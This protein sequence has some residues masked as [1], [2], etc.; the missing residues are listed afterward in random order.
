MKFL[1]ID[2]YY[3][4]FLAEFRASHPELANEPFDR[5]RAAL[6]GTCFG[7]SDYYSANL[8]KLG[9]GAQ[10]LIINDEHLQRRWA[11]E[12]N[13]TVQRAGLW[14]KIQTLP[15]IHRAI[16]RPDWMQAITL[17]QIAEIRPDVV[18]VQDLSALNPE[19][20]RKI[21]EMT[22][23]LVGQIACPLPAAE[24]LR[25]FQLIL[26]SFPHYVDRFRQ[27]GIASEYLKIAF[28]PRVLDR[29]GKQERSYDVSFVGSFSPHHSE[30]TKLLERIA[31]KQPIHIWGQGSQFLSPTSPLRANYHGPAWGLDMYKILAQSKI[32]INRHISVAEDYA[33][34]MRLYET[35]GMGALLMTDAKKNLS[36]LFRVDQ[37][38]IAYESG[39]DLSKKIS[40]YLDHDEERAAIARAGQARTLKEHTY[41]E[42][43]KEVIVIIEKYL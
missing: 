42:R 8:T 20:L 4:Q 7:T 27:M 10:D 35:T 2:T 31:K 40:Y 5:Q 29:V 23:L 36:D 30:G 26:T 13:L 19:T 22:K 25:E 15:L 12:H 16:G 38:V 41:Q 17:A 39:E 28:E 1:L 11:A 18:Y 43:M 37:E 6:L 21:K 9:H 3:P 33:N 14:Q 24:N 34:N 32:V